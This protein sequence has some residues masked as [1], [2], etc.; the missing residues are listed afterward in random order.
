MNNDKD[1]LTKKAEI[2]ETNFLQ[3]MGV[4][5]LGKYPEIE[6]HIDKLTDVLIGENDDLNDEYTVE[7]CENMELE[8]DDKSNAIDS[9]S[10]TLSDM[11]K[12]VNRMKT[13]ETK[14]MLLSYIESMEM[15]LC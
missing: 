3:E 2:L 15:D 8:L 10:A 4:D 6:K 5:T 7:D 14:T 9:A 1:E 13:S 12:L 11:K